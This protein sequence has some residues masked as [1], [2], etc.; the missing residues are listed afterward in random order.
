MRK[1]GNDVT[2]IV[3]LW[4]AEG[5]LDRSRQRLAAA[6]ATRTVSSFAECFALLEGP[7]PAAATAPA[8]GLPEL[9]VP[10]P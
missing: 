7:T 5:D 3:G 10:A 9:A 1:D 8:E 2:I 6:G 4:C